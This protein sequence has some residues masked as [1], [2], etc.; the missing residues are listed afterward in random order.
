MFERTVTRRE[1]LCLPIAA[2]LLRG[3]PAGRRSEELRRIAAPEANQAVA[4]DDE[5]PYAIG[6]HVIAK[7]DKKTGKRLSVWEFENGKP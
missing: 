6:N 7:Y 4:A 2:S 5:F 1:A 3:A